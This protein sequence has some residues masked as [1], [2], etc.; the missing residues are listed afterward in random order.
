MF[1]KKRSHSQKDSSQPVLLK[2]Y[3]DET[4]AILCSGQVLSTAQFGM[5][6]VAMAHQAQ[7]LFSGVSDLVKNCENAYKN[8]PEPAKDAEASLYFTNIFDLTEDDILEPDN[9]EDL[10]H[11]FRAIEDSAKEGA[12][13]LTASYV[14][15]LS[16]HMSHLAENLSGIAWALLERNRNSWGAYRELWELHSAQY[17]E[18]TVFNENLDNWK[19]ALLGLHLVEEELRLAQFYY[20]L[21]LASVSAIDYHKQTGNPF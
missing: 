19:R 1:L 17:M 2:I 21:C 20:N 18:K 7:T 3:G 10:M 11:Y 6:I 12:Y 14:T 5:R 8:S 13:A 15:R 9:I 16:V 4:Q